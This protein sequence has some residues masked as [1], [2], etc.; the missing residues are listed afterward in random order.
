[1]AVMFFF[2]VTKY[3]ND[4]DFIRILN[5]RGSFKFRYSKAKSEVNYIMRILNIE[6]LNQ[7]LVDLLDDEFRKD[8]GHFGYIAYIGYT[9][10]TKAMLDDYNWVNKLGITERD[11]LI[12]RKICKE[13]E[14]KEYMIA[15]M[16]YG[17]QYRKI[18]DSYYISSPEDKKI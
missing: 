5:F 11:R 1:M 3:F 18:P 13:E 16:A 7:Y 6:R 4:D 2:A 14:E 8:S 9:K 10:I 12:I 17:A 15:L